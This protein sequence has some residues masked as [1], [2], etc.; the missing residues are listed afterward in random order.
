MSEGRGPQSDIFIV[1]GA[2]HS[3][4]HVVQALSR[5]VPDNEASPMTKIIDSKRISPKR[6]W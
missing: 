3:K 6:P 2:N 1:L 4:L 5:V